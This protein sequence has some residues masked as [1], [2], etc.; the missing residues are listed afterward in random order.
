M[1]E[2]GPNARQKKQLTERLGMSVHRMWS[3]DSVATEPHRNA[4]HASR[5]EGGFANTRGFVATRRTP[6][7]L[8][9]GSPTRLDPLSC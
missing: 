8:G 7:R 1:D 5:V 9:R 3:P 2:I 4:P 6:S